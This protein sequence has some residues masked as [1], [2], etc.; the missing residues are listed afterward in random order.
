LATIAFSFTV[1]FVLFKVIGAVMGG[2]RP[3]SE[4][5]ETGLDQSEHAETG[6]VL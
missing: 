2:L 3:D 5:E 4:D 6:Y 1:S